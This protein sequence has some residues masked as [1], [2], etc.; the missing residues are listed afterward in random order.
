MMPAL[1]VGV[2][3]TCLLL[4]ELVPTAK[5]MAFEVFVG[6]RSLYCDLRCFCHHQNPLSHSLDFV[7]HVGRFKPANCLNDPSLEPFPPRSNRTKS[8]AMPGKQALLV[9]VERI[10]QR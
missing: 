7:Q 8:R 9:A 10:V 2:N 1:I 3:Q 5:N 6:C 4:A